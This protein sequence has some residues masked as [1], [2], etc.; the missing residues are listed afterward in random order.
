[1]RAMTHVLLAVGGIAVATPVLAQ[2]RVFRIEQA[3]PGEIDPAKATD[4]S[5]LILASNIYDTLLWPAPGGGVEPRAAASWKVSDDKQSYTF[6]LRDGLKFH[7]GSGVT[8]D[9]VVFSFNRFMKLGAGYSYLFAGVVDAVKAD[10]PDS[11]TFTLKHPHAPF[12]ASVVRLSIVSKA[13]V[14]AH[15]A[16]GSFGEWGDYGQGYLDQHDAGSGAYSV[17][18]HD[19]QTL[20]VMKKFNSY[21]LPFPANAPTEVRMSYSVEDATLRA[22]MSRG[23]LDVSSMWHPN[24]VIADLAKQPGISAGAE[25]V[26]GEGLIKFNTKRPPMDNVHF[27]RAVAAAIDYD[28]IQSI[29][30]VT[31][32]IYS[33]I[34]SR[35]PIPDGLPGSDP[36]G[37]IP[38]RDLAAAKQE[39]AQAGYDPASAPIEI[40]SAL[41]CALHQKIALLVSSNLAELGVKTQ[42]KEMPWALV[43]E[44]A[45]KMESTPH[46]TFVI[47]NLAAPDV[48]LFLTETYDFSSAGRWSSMEWLENKDI[49]KLISDARTE[50]DPVKR[51]DI[52]SHINKTILD[53]Q[54]DA[55]ALQPVN[56]FAKRENVT[57]PFED[58]K[59]A[60]G[61]V[62][63]DFEFRL[64]QVK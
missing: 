48:D 31:D 51:A 5:G 59:N 22:L 63:A 11:V 10:G 54:P 2:E 8:A 13:V 34:P 47:Q 23:Q 18:A 53:L 16:D 64:V 35:G 29:L 61:L 36:N 26:Y 44:S 4:F 39:L 27:R 50:L 25:K 19:K 24:E 41:C 60:T 38:K 43:V 17:A 21:Y 1:M 55:W 46:I 28:A 6:K 45:S 33:G 40:L 3:A 37:P 62:A 30:K 14:S 49:D 52:Y 9:D 56:V 42:I 58:P 20:T 32:K 15:K 57:L 7:D 12:L